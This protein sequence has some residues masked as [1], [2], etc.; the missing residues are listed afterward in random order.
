MHELVLLGRVALA[1][2]LSAVVGLE[3][4]FHGRPAGLRTH[5][6]VAVG[7][8]LVM[9]TFEGATILVASNGG[10]ANG[11]QIDPGRLAAGI[12]TGIGFLGAGTILRVGDW[13]RGLTTAASVWF[14][15]AIGIVSGEGLYVLALGATAIGFLILTVVGRLEQRLPTTVYHRISLEV[16]PEENDAV[17]TLFQERCAAHQIRPQLTAWESDAVSG[18]VVMRYRVRH[19]GQVPLDEFAAEL[20]TLP[21]VLEVKAEL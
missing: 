20:S 12:I 15:A 5:L 2:A 14:V 17:R 7:S 4:E 6:L 3:R 21:G 19:R 11:A 8:A 1:A 10:F 18:Q 9:V 16:L 13:V